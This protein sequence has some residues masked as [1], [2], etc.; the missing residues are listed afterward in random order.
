MTYVTDEN[1]LIVLKFANNLI[2][3][4]NSTCVYQGVR[5]VRFPKKIWHAMFSPNSGFEIH[6]FPYYQR[7]FFKKT[8]VSSDM[9]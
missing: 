5:N 8:Y 4:C 3:N 7:I 2:G 6:L 9:G 1:T